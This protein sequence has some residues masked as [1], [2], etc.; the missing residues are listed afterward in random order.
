M[1]IGAAIL[2]SGNNFSKVALM[3]RFLRLHF[4]SI[5]TYQRIQRTYLVPAIEAFWETKQA[6]IVDEFKDKQMVLLGKCSNIDNH[7]HFLIF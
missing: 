3:A 6:E 1:L 2:L 7:M 4:V 5:S